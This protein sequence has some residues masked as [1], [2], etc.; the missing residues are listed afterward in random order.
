MLGKNIQNLGR[1]VGIWPIVQGEPY[2]ILGGQKSLAH[3]AQPAAIPPKRWEKN[4]KTGKQKIK[5]EGTK[6]TMAPLI[7]RQCQEGG[8][9]QPARC[10]PY[11]I[12]SHF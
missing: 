5:N 10:A 3:R 9:N 1:L 8:A 7:Q 4:R 2:L 11:K 6:Q 12:F